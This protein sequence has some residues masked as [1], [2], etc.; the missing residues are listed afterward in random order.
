MIRGQVVEKQRECD[1]FE[2]V[3]IRRCIFDRT[4]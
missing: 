2:R 4:M 3:Y 1:S